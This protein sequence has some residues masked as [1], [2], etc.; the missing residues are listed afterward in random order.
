MFCG[1]AD[2]TG[3]GSEEAM[4]SVSGGKAG[5]GGPGTGGVRGLR[6]WAGVWGERC[7]MPLGSCAPQDP[8]PHQGSCARHLPGQL[9]GG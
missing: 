5:G 6:D 9:W 2:L 4:A 1:I 8:A 3:L 7:G